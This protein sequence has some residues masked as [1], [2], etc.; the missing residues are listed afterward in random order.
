MKKLLFLSV[1]V[2][3]SV[4]CGKSNDPANDSLRNGFKL[5]DTKYGDVYRIE[6]PEKGNLIYVIESNTTGNCGITVVPM[7]K[8]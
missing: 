7:S 6:D 8:K 4:G 1:V 5:A 3:L 2:V